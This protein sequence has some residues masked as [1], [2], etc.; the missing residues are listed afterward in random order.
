[1]ESMFKVI[2]NSAIS[3]SVFTWNRQL[4]GG[5][6]GERN[7]PALIQSFLKYEFYTLLNV[8]VTDSV[9]YSSPFISTIKYTCYCLLFHV[10]F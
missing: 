7:S 10:I 4:R 8:I 5:L 6:H 9:F 3:K 1:M 2:S